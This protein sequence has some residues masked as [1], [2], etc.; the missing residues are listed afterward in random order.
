[1]VAR[2]LPE[3]D[4][5]GQAMR[6]RDL[7]RL[8]RSR[9]SLQLFL[10]DSGRSAAEVLRGEPADPWLGARWISDPYARIY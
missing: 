7:L 9:A 10:P 5:P 1:M 3:I 2:F 4:L 8:S 6:L